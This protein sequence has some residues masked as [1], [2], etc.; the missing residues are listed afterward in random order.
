VIILTALA[1]IDRTNEAVTVPRP[2]GL[3]FIFLYYYAQTF[4][5][6]YYRCATC[7]GS[8]GCRQGRV[9]EFMKTSTVRIKGWG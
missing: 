2:E 9:D 4:Q 8:S 3:G 6:L 7:G 5:L 1:I